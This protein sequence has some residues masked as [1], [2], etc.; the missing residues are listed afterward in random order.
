M[1]GLRTALVYDERCLAHDNGSMLLDGAAQSWLSVP[2]VESPDRI[3]RTVQVLER[4]GV[5]ERVAPVAARLASEEEL[6][7]VHSDEHIATIREACSS[8]ELRWIG[9]EARA[10]PQSWEPALLAVGGT[11]AAADWMFAESD[12]RAYVLMR[13]PGHHSSAALSMGFCLFN[14]VAVAARHVQRAHG[15]GRV[16]IVDWDVHH[17]NG[18]QEIFYEDPS[19]LFVSLHQD[20]LY[21]VGSGRL[22]DIGAGAGE[23]YTVNVPLPAG[24]GDLTYL[25][26][27]ESVVS[28]ILDRFSPDFLIVS[29]GQDPAASDPLGRMSVTTEGF[30]EMTRRL[31]ASAEASCEGRVLAYQEGGYSADHMPFC[32]AAIVEALAGLEPS[33]ETDPMELDVP[34]AIGEAQSAAVAAVAAHHRAHWPTL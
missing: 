2:H 1:V 32:T 8:G 24:S 26:A 22:G 3:E 13:P 29:A 28:P 23:G 19:V 17:G 4:S 12:R 20:D 18:T 6:R 11:I 27:I 10:G 14:C 5:R 9:P 33:F 16:A 25:Q 15:A 7:L 21:P 31:L 34:A 30:R